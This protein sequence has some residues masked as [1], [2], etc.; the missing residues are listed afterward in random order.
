MNEALVCKMTKAKRLIHDYSGLNV[1]VC[2]G[3]NVRQDPYCN[4][5][6]WVQVISG[7]CIGETVTANV[8][9]SDIGSR[10]LVRVGGPGKAGPLDPTPQTLNPKH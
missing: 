6:R 4:K 7:A 5:G 10:L 9:L 3:I 8:E 1:Y 2:M